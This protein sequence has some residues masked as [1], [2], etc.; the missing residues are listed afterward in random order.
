[1]SKIGKTADELLAERVERARGVFT[2]TQIHN[3]ECRAREDAEANVYRP[4]TPDELLL[5]QDI[6][7]QAFNRRKYKIAK[8]KREADG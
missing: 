3:W 2:S 6:Y 1:M 8:A 7:M 4:P 5:A